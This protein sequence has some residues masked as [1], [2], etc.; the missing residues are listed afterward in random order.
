MQIA[1]NALICYRCGRATSD[2]RIK[3]PERRGRR[4][5]GLLPSVVALL[6]LVIAA[7]FLGSVAHQQTPRLVSWIVAVLAAFLV[8]WRLLRGRSR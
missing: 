7:L 5:V 4:P 1:D 8:V 3:P 6:L 2:P